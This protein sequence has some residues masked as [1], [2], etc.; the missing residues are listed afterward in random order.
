MSS[1]V[2]SVL[3]LVAATFVVA[4][5]G[6]GSSS[7]G[8]VTLNWWAGNQPGGSFDKAAEYCNAAVQGRV[9]D[10]LQ[11]ARRQR[12][13]PAPAARSPPRRQGL[14][15]RPARHGRRVDLGVRRGQVDQAL[16]GATSRRGAKDTLQGPLATAT[17]QG[18]LYGGAGE[19]QHAAA[20]VP[21]GQGQGRRPKTWDELITRPSRCTHKVEVQAAA[22]RGL[23]GVDQ[24]ADRV[25]RRADPRPHR[26]GTLEPGPAKALDIISA[27][28]TSSA[29][30][31]SIANSKEDSAA[32]PSSRRGRLPGQLP[33]HLSRARAAR[34]GLPGQ[35]GWAPYPR[36]DAGDAGQGADRRL[37]LRRRRLHE[38]PQGGVRR[39][40]LPAQL[41]SPA[42]RRASRAACPRRSRRSTTTRTSRRTIRSRT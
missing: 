30:D 25:R 19:L 32:S 10:Q 41:S 16:P 2:T 36:V 22:V 29:A 24:L 38:A 8:T 35:I 15:D 42:H 1:R 3:A 40:R 5:C 20:L 28:A 26:Q 18:K 7:S 9:R 12:R 13:P 21:Q 31:P 39:R 4:A 11:Q 34:Q 14:L 23:H 33:V 6:G 37:Q 27:L 17:Y